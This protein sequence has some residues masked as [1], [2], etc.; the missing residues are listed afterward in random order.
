M[1]DAVSIRQTDLKK[2]QIG[3]AITVI[4][5]AV[6]IPVLIWLILP[7]VD[8]NYVMTFFVLLGG[9]LYEL[10]S[11]WINKL[12]AYKRAVIDAVEAGKEPPKSEE[13]FKYGTEFNKMFYIINGASFLLAVSVALYLI[14]TNAV[15]YDNWI[16]N[17]VT[18]F[19][20]A[21]GQ[22]KIIKERIF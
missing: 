14:S 21:V 13:Y 18:N 5:L 20:Y 8:A 19:F 3:L 7:K 10:F 16:S 22:A 9:T 17:A 15:V 6:G 1:V 12:L 11:P 4:S 2:P